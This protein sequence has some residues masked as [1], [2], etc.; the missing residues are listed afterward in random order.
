LVHATAYSARYT[1]FNE[2]RAISHVLTTVSQRNPSNHPL[3]ITALSQN[4]SVTL[5]LPRSF[6]G[7]LTVRTHNGSYKPTPALD[8]AVT[9]FSE[10]D[11]LR[12]SFIGDPVGSGYLADPEAWQGG[13]VTMESKNGTLRIGWMDESHECPVS[14]SGS[15]KSFWTSV[16]KGK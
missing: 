15:G 6:V 9:T 2:S 4:G 16:F 5:S 11:G 12:K 14:G 1:G 10:H 7:P 3:S 8:S 13:E